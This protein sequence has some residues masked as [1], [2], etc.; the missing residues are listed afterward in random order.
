VI[1]QGSHELLSYPG[2]VQTTITIASTNAEALRKM[3]KKNIDALKV[4]NRREQS[5]EGGCPAC[6]QRS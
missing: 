4:S 6:K 5:V 2:I 1:N 3:A